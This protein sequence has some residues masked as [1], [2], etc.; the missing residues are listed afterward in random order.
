MQAKVL[1]QAQG[2]ARRS[3]SHRIEAEYARLRPLGE[4]FV[5]RRFSGQLNHQDAEDVVADVLAR[6]HSRETEGRGPDNLQAA[7]FT[8]LRN[9]AIDTLRARGI[10]PEV[11]LEA[12]AGADSGAGPEESAEGAQE[13][14]VLSEAL[15]RM[16]RN[17]REAILLRYGVGLTVPEIAER[18]R[19]SLPAAKKLVLRATRQVKERLLTVTSDEH[20]S[21]MREL[22]RQALFEKEAAG[23]ATAEEHRLLRAHLAH[24][25]SCRAFAGQLHDRLHGVAAA[26]LLASSEQIG[27]PAGVVDHLSGWLSG[28]HEH[29]DAI[30]DRG[31][32]LA[33]RAGGGGAPH[34]ADGALGAGVATTG[35]KV[36]AVCAGGAAAATCLATG[37]VGPGIAPTHGKD[38]APP[39]KVKTGPQPAAPASA[40]EPSTAAD[41][42]AG[43]TVKPSADTE[44]Q[45]FGT[46]SPPD[47][48]GDTREF[49]PAPSTSSSSSGS[50]G[51]GGGGRGKESFGL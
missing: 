34:G 2:I 36:A 29:A 15:A 17:Y 46:A 27:A 42:A 30:A 47:S 21:E 16:R 18:K 45:N 14:A 8:A 1:D 6:F 41:D 20:C 7:F 4:S 3:G 48:N 12:A 32:E 23:I 35:A 13:G 28:A 22:T 37:V 43:D 38:P 49:G 33:F 51:G 44:K 5:R 26:A 40:A 19:I 10:R 25:G 50:G 24:C 39:A 31:R 11:P 9:Q